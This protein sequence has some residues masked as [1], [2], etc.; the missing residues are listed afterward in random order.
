MN[1]SNRLTKL[2]AVIAVA[3]AVS[4]EAR[5]ISYAPYT[6]RTA[7]PAHGSRLNRHF[8]LLESPGQPGN[9]GGSPFMPGTYNPITRQAV[10]YDFTGAEEPRVIYP[11]DGSFGEIVFA[12]VRE[13]ASGVPAI[14][15]QDLFTP[16]GIATPPTERRLFL[17]TDGGTTWN[18]V[19]GAPV[20]QIVF[21]ADFSADTGGP[22]AAGKYAQVRIGT[23]DLPFVAAANNTVYT[24]GR[25]AVAQVVF[26]AT[27]PLGDPPQPG[28]AVLAGRDATGSRFLV[29]T[30]EGLHIISAPGNRTLVTSNFGSGQVEGWITPQG[31]VYVEH[32]SDK[33]R[34]ALIRG[35]STTVIRE[36]PITGNSQLPLFAIPSFDYNDAWIIERAPGQPTTL[37]RHSAGAGL[38][39]Q[40]DDI[41]GPEVEALHAG[42]SGQKLLIQVHRPRPQPDQRLFLDPAL[43]VWTVGQP[44]PR[45]Y[46]ELF[47]NE[48]FNKGFVRVNVEN[49]EEGEPFV[50]D[51]GAANLCISCGGGVGVSPATPGGGGDVVQEWGVVRASLKQQLILPAV[52]RTPGAFGSFWVTDLIV[53]NPSD[54]QQRV[55]IRYAGNGDAISAAAAKTITLTLQP[56]EIRHVEDAL[57]EL[58]QIETGTGS[59]FITPES[60]VNVTSRTYSR[61]ALG[62]FGFGM[63]AIDIYAAAASPRFPVSFAGAFPGANFRTNL[64][65][66][67]T[68]SRGTLAVAAASG[69]N[70]PIG[71]SDLSFE[72]VP[73]G[74]QQFNNLGTTLGLHP[75]ESGALVIRPSRGAAVA[76]VFVVDNRTN[77]STY[78][79]PDLPAPSVRTIPVIGHINGANNSRFRSDLYLFN[80]APAPRTVVLQASPWDT[81]DPTSPTLSL[82]L[83]GNEARVIKD[84]LQTIFGKTGLARLRYQSPGDAGGV[85]VTSR[86]Y[87]ID[88]NGGTYGFLMP[89]LNNFQG[90]GSGDTLEI[91]GAVADDNFRTN[92]G[93]VGLA[94]MNG[95]DTSARVQIIDGA[96]LTVDTFTVNVPSAGGMQLNDVF[97]ARA[98]AVD[99]PVLIRVTVLSGMIGAYATYTDNRTNDSVYLAANLAATE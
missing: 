81:S 12:A 52:G 79:P 13:D 20:P 40:W 71:L 72:A 8:V 84:A 95:L 10:L 59:F 4:A 44:A 78:F 70:G 43:A 9:F 27:P 6:N 24:I 15:I 65:I 94:L 39:K 46:D 83:L 37:Y 58:F 93:L 5:V 41:T 82:T 61:S 67:D 7:Q 68:S 54:A 32:R 30:Q 19:E 3:I 96:G 28:R 14:L 55:D 73:N 38:V 66:T 57:A 1:M 76:S 48:Q 23:H 99:G 89:P 63:N 35:G 33:V 31:D 80:T 90:G 56:R 53:H 22:F 29:Q 45:F 34:L 92:I 49:I 87:N 88:E 98:L 2:L 97:R 47:L 21:G 64:V 11:T 50:F 36:A 91:L 60:G 75:T 42:S 86:T 16:G 62:T 18:R 85:R 77:D 26:T 51:S 74:Q 25:N 17:S 69:L